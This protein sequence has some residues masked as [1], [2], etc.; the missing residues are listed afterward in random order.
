MNSKTDNLLTAEATLSDNSTKG[1]PSLQADILG[2]WR[3]EAI[4]RTADSSALRIYTTTAITEYRI[5]ALMHDPVY[6]LGVAAENVAYNQ[7]PHTSYY[8]GEGMMQ[9]PAPHIYVIYPADVHINPNFL[10]LNSNGG[11]HSVTAKI[12]LR[13]HSGA[14]AV[15]IASVTLNVYGGKL[16]GEDAK[17]DSLTR[18]TVKFD[19]QQLIQ[20]LSG[21]TGEVE[22][23]ITGRLEDGSQF[24][25]T[26]RILVQ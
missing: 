25:G 4:W 6:R 16:Q 22:V 10:N 11:D 23:K 7:P 24:I 21:Q 1:N 20:A 18:F 9:P 8:L 17:G 13:D 5:P 15:G 19:R 26:D 12:D 3:E 14:N 2:D